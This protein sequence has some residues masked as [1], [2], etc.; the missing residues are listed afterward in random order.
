MHLQLTYTEPATFHQL[1]LLDLFLPDLAKGWELLTELRSQYPLLPI[2][3]LSSSKDISIIR[4]AYELGAHS[5]LSKPSNLD[6]WES[7][8][9]TLSVYW[10][11][12]ISLASRSN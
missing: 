9:Q 3:V 12:I 1:V 5:F 10:F 11:G 7:T 6:E 2:V 8:F 4:Q